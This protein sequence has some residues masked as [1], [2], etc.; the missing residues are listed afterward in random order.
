[1]TQRLVNPGSPT[2]AMGVREAAEILDTL[3]GYRALSW[4][5]ARQYA[6]PAPVAGSEVMAGTRAYDD[7]VRTA[8]GDARGTQAGDGNEAG[9]QRPLGYGTVGF[10]R[11]SLVDAYSEGPR[12][13]RFYLDTLP[14]HVS[15]EVRWLLGTEGLRY[16]GISEHSTSLRPDR[17]QII[18]LLDEEWHTR[19]RLSTETE[20]QRQGVA[21]DRPSARYPPHW[22]GDPEPMAETRRGHH[23]LEEP[24]LGPAVG[25]S[26]RYECYPD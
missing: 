20:D 25:L 5:R 21:P 18:D 24:R 1:M 2:P 13:G 16:L 11:D 4:R 12:L 19:Q 10:V 8:L 6:V 17:Q 7:L 14:D 22:L 3:R 15:R 26:P 23:Y 9:N